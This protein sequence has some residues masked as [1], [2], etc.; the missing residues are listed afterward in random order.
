MSSH[1]CPHTT[2]TRWFQHEA[3]SW[4]E[5]AW[6]RAC[7]AKQIRDKPPAAPAP[8]PRETPP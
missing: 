8:L 5:V 3:L 2:L 4:C 6:C 1:H 7:G